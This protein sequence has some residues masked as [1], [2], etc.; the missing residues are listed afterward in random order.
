METITVTKKQIEDYHQRHSDF[1]PPCMLYS[2]YLHKAS[3]LF[4]MTLNECRNKYGQFTMAQWA[5]LFNKQ[6]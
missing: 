1:L 5:N 2:E 4:N 3:D 6:N